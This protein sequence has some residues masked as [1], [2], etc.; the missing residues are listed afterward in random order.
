MTV[1][2]KVAMLVSRKVDKMGIYSVEKKVD[3]MEFSMVGQ[4][5]V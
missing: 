4:L 2:Q 1:E 3:L 5:V